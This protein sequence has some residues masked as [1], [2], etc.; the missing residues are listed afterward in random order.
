[1]EDVRGPQGSDI[2]S[3]LF[4]PP[5]GAYLPF[6]EG[7]RAC[8]SRR[9]AQVEIIAVL[10]VLFREYSVELAVDEWASDEEVDKMPVGGV[11]RREVWEK[12]AG[13]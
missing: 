8:L 11:E 2:A 13:G 10:A 3:S 7:Y 5:R 6:S 9:F 4:R 1:M 12:A